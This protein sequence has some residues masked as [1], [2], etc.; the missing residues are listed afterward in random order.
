MK[1]I[2]TIIDAN[3]PTVAQYWQ[4]MKQYRSLI[5]IFAWQEIAVLYKQTR[6]GLLWAVLRPLIIL[7]IFS[8]L[9]NTLLQV[10]TASPYY[11]FAFTGMIA[12]NLFSNITSTASTAILSR[13]DLIRKMYFPKLVLPLSKIL[14]VGVEFFISLAIIFAMMLF[15]GM[16]LQ[17]NILTLPLF[18]FLNIAAGLAVAVWM[19]ALTVRFRDLHQ[20]VPPLIGMGIWL[21]PV[22]FPTTIIPSQYHFLLWFNPMAG[23]ISGYRFAL[24]GEAFPESQ[25]FISMMA[26]VVLMLLGIWYLIRVED[27]MADSL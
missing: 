10:D 12:W 3:P 25:F 24:L 23:V 1:E 16:K 19:N 20:I 15:E 4:K 22:F 13:Q 6:L 9:F 11:I 26:M 17:W 21:T 14:V 8:V 18:I 7:L 27:E 5:W 2:I